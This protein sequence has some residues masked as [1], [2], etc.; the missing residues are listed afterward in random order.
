VYYFTDANQIQV[1]SKTAG[2]WL[3]PFPIPHAVRLYGIALSPDGSKLAVTDPG[4]DT[5]DVLNPDS[6]GSVASF[7]LPNTVLDQGTLPCGV[8]ATDSGI[9]YYVSYD[10]PIS[11]VN[12]HHELDT[13]TGAVKDLPGFVD[14]QNSEDAY[15][16]LL[17]ANDG[18]RLFLCMAGFV[19]AIDTATDETVTNP[20]S[21]E[22]DYELT[23]SSNGTWMSAA[24]YLMDTDVNP[25]AFVALNEREV[26]NQ[27]AVYGEKISADGNLLFA[28]LTNAIDVY[29]G[30]LGTF[31]ARV[32]LP[33][34]L[35]PNYDALVSDGKDN[36]LIAITGTT[37]GGI[38]VVDLSSLP[39]PLPLPYSSALARRVEVSRRLSP[40]SYADAAAQ[41]ASAQTQRL[42]SKPPRIP[43]LTV[44]H[45]TR[46]VLNQQSPRASHR[47]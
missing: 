35:S 10:P 19:T 27:L 41:S 42:Y 23:L 22:G 14:G 8:A 29:D 33:F 46:A 45:N 40:R 43:H 11:G 13:A 39:E 26:W 34:P 18:S 1:F 16:R 4:N 2:K 12:A 25:E 5:V 28:P 3:A 7:S 17:L 30:R 6:P 24:E 36:V 21:P 37:G 15:T 31:R 32:A 38:A 47:D 20:I 44:Q 9:V